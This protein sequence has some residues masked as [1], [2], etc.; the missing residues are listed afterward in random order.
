VKI[1]RVLRNKK[2]ILRNKKGILRNKKG[3][4]LTR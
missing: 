1:C 2:G 4:A 3:K